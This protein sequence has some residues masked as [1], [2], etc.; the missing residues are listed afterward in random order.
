MYSVGFMQCTGDGEEA[1]RPPV[2]SP[3]KEQHILKGSHKPSHERVPSD[4]VNESMYSPISPHSEQAIVT[5]KGT[6]RVNTSQDFENIP[7]QG[8]ST[9]V[10]NK[11]SKR[12]LMTAKS[13]EKV[14]HLSY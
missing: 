8:S 13:L 1:I 11:K 12:K 9:C 2:C 7:L 14:I 10:M 4:I 5:P 3:L 6:V